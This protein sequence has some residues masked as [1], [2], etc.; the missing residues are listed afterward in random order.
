VGDAAAARRRLGND[1]VIDRP[2]L[3]EVMVFFSRGGG[4][5]DAG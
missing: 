5:V 4:D 3:D 1:L 2:S